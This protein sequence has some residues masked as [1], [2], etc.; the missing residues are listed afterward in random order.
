MTG[1]DSLPVQ[2]LELCREVGGTDVFP[3]K[4]LGED[5]S[6]AHYALL[7]LQWMGRCTAPRA[8]QGSQQGPCHHGPLNIVTCCRG[9]GVTSWEHGV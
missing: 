7:W 4:V 1:T 9:A 6:V 3:L 8:E 2:R 5:P